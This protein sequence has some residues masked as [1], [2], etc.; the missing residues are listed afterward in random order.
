MMVLKEVRQGIIEDGIRIGLPQKEIEKF[1]KEEDNNIKIKL[2]EELPHLSE[3]YRNGELTN[4]IET[5][6]RGKNLNKCIKQETE[7]AKKG[8]D[9]ALKGCLV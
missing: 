4:Q 9:A 7:K 6:L 3:T 2:E 8:I 1:F 5:L